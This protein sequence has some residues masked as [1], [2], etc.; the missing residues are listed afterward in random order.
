MMYARVSALL[1]LEFLYMYENVHSKSLERFYNKWTISSVTEFS[2]KM[3][4]ILRLFA[5]WQDIG[6]E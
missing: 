2:N 3:Q 5:V 1:F 6:K 4:L